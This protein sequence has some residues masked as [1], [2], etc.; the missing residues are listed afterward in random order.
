MPLIVGSKLGP[1]EIVAPL[2]VG[3]MGEVYR[4]RDT[5][6][7]REV[8]IK[9]LPVDLAHDEDRLARFR[10]EAQVLGSLN[11]PHIAAIYGLEESNGITAL[12]LELVEG[13]TLADR[14]AQGAIPL[15]ETLPVARQIAEALESAHDRGIIHR[16]LK[17]ANIKLTPDG[18]AKVLDFGLA[19]ALETEAAPQSG[20]MSPTLS[21]HATHAGVI[22]GT[23][24]YMSPEQARGRAVDKRTDIWAFG[25]V[26]YEM[27]TGRRLFEGED[28]SETMAFVITR[29]PDWKALPPSTP[30]SIRK[31]LRRCLERNR[32]KRL[33]DIADAKLEIDEAIAE[34]QTA[35]GAAVAIPAGA[36]ARGTLA[37]VSTAAL[38]A[39]LA[40]AA[41][42][43]WM[44]GVWTPRPL[45]V[46]RFAVLPPS[47]EAL[48]T[49]IPDRPLAITPDGK[50]IV[51]MSESG[52]LA[53]PIDRVNATRLVAGTAGRNPFMSADSKSVGFFTVAELRRIAL[54]GGPQLSVT[55]VSAPPRGASWGSDDKIVYATAAATT[56]LLRVPASGGAT[57]VLTKPDRSRGEI[58]HVL[59]SILPN[60]RGVLFTIITVGSIAENAQ[61]A[62][63]D[64]RS[65]AY[66]VLIAGGSQPEFVDDGFLVYA[67]S[68]T[69]RAIRFDQNRMET[70][71]DSVPVVEGV[72][73]FTSGAAAFSVSRTGTLI[74]GPASAT[75]FS[76]ARVLVWVDRQGREEFLSAPPRLYF[77][78]RLSPD[79]S[80]VAVDIRDQEN[81]I[82]IWHNAPNTLTRL[83]REPTNDVFP[84][85]MDNR[86]VAYSSPRDGAQNLYA[87]LADGTGAVE[88]LSTSPLG[89]FATSATPD[90][91]QLVILQQSP[92]SGNDLALV[93]VGDNSPPTPL[94][95]TAAADGPAEISPDG[96]WLAYESEES[97]QYQI[98][99]RPFPD[100]NSSRAQI[101]PS[102]GR[103]PLW[104]RNSPELFY[105]D[106]EGTMTSVAVD[107]RKA[108]SFGTPVKLF[109]GSYFSGVQARGYDVSLDGKRFLMIKNASR[110]EADPSATAQPSM[111]AV[112]NWFAELRQKLQ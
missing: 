112:V 28:A 24:A 71:G 42:A 94:V 9:V 20:T 12:V 87:Q 66:K 13:P 47:G 54:S 33:A 89:Q 82:W 55:K 21:L 104:A 105:Q 73:G 4:A 43:A 80:R 74:Y 23:A 5:R 1:Y 95:Q 68:G 109:K 50:H 61:I 35:Q 110:P 48:I 27:L 39:G 67:T 88:R 10:R 19:K 101:S 72:G 90:G 60:G 107:T 25:C 37:W 26:L 106:L 56:G 30:A 38:L 17:P 108:F 59:P 97:G 41:V 45:Q 15:D 63:L 29:E 86:R 85:W 79:G 91:R 64:F 16:D 51:F 93:T 100:V 22:L 98:Y 65:G 7:G 81:D 44:L 49:T 8:A 52:L 46:M 83:T 75:G 18:S 78:V 70:L 102:G 53:R 2:G 69:L 32:A 92:Q 36:P 3:G 14:V 58:D 40:I 62:V 96:R 111:I 31:L 57:E 103:K 11:H 34:P 77:T 99:V 84:V 6:L 76:A